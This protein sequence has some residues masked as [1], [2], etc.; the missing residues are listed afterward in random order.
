MIKKERP[1]ITLERLPPYHCELNA[2]E[3]VQAIAKNKVRKSPFKKVHDVQ[4]VAR[5]AFEEI[6]PEM[7]GN[8]YDH[9]KGAGG[10]LQKSTWNRTIISRGCRNC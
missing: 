7:I 3:L 5:R 8:I 2:I 4:A 9:I 1:D 6:T 10:L